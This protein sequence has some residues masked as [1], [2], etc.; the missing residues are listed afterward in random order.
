M[1]TERYEITRLLGKG[2]TG[3][4]Y[5]AE[6]TRLQRKVALRR[7]FSQDGI[8]D[9]T[10]YKADFESI[11]QNLSALQHPNL[12]RVFDAGVDE[13]GAFIIS[14]LLEGECFHQYMKEKPLTPWEANDLAQQLMEAMVTAHSA[15]FIHGAIT[16]GSILMT[17]RAR[18]GYLYV[19]LDLGL[20]RL[21]PLIQGPDSI[22]AM[23]ADPAIMAPELFDGSPADE[24]SDLYMCGQII[25]MALAGGH[26]Y[27]G[28]GIK[29]AEKLHHKGL[30]DLL[31][32]CPEMPADFLQWLMQLT[33]INA[34]DRTSTALEALQSLPKVE[35]PATPRAPTLVTGGAAL[36]TPSS[37]STAVQ[38]NQPISSQVPNQP[39]Q[40][41]FTGTLGNAVTSPIPSG[42]PASTLGTG[43]HSVSSGTPPKKLSP[44][45]IVI[46]A[47]ALLLI[48]L[49]L[50]VTSSS[51]E[52]TGEQIAK[53]RKEKEAKERNESDD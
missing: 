34:S 14:Q 13:D 36:A 39:A 6:D 47:A 51:G 46:V 33:Q 31:E 48:P 5:E 25:Y 30:P 35:K 19:I 20:S 40:G 7:F 32:Y 37:G 21:A 50:W 53:E 2:R 8:T 22:L 29:E 26:P 38:S 11:A 41:G 4:V 10:G 24:R 27:G 16:P 52:K 15:G 42:G 44:W 12:L 1:S 3:G 23:M 18:G 28:V 17:P 9:L 45:L 49:I 43:V